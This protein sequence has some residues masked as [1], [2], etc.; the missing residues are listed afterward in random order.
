MT[1]EGSLPPSLNDSMGI[2][3]WSSSKGV[4]HECEDPV[5]CD[6]ADR[7]TGGPSYP[8]RTEQNLIDSDGTLI[9][10]YGVLYPLLAQIVRI[11]L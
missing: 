9:I 1:Q 6:P 3:A 2:S 5:Y 8:K 4:K 11:E 7:G 10:S